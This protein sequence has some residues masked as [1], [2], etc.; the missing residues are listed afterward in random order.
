MNTLVYVFIRYSA[1]ILLALVVSISVTPVLLNLKVGVTSES[2]A[3]YVFGIAMGDSP[4]ETSN[5][6]CIKDKK[7]CVA[8]LPRWLFIWLWLVRFLGWVIMPTIVALIVDRMSQGVEARRLQ[9]QND[10]KLL[11]EQENLIIN[12]VDKRIAQIMTQ[13]NT[14]MEIHEIEQMRDSVI[15]EVD[16]IFTNDNV[17][18]NGLRRIFNKGKS[19][20]KRPKAN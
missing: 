14:D 2:S 19:I 18:K 9:E 20:I 13:I 12:T 4:Y 16:R 8:S 15:D 11:L 1:V 7:N 3:F 17:E 5:L 6:R 10:R